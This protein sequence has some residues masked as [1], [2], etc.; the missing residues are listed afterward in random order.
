M[1][2]QTGKTRFTLTITDPTGATPATG[3]SSSISLMPMMHM[4]TKMHGTPMDTTITE[5]APGKYTCT[6]YYIMGTIT[7]GKA[8]GYW[9]LR[10]KIGSMAG[11][12]AYFY[13]YVGGMMGSYGQLLGTNDLI[14][15][16]TGTATRTYYLFN[17]GLITDPTLTTLTLFIAAKE[18]M[19]SYPAIASGDI[20]TLH[21]GNGD[22]WTIGSVLVTASIDNWATSYT[23]VE[24]ARGHWT[25][26]TGIGLISGV[27]NTVLVSLTVDG[28][29]KTTATTAY[30]TFAVRP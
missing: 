18:S 30:A 6:A 1:G 21:D 15:S 20:V 28:E 27:T 11:E 13:P 12:S 7:S 26:P 14:S 29:L 25:I 24:G 2:A 3:L 9:E 19:D 8:A 22:P 23:A 16:G 10:V 4:P 5:D 17:D